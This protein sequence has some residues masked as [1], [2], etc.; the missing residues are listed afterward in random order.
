LLS[1][2]SETAI[3][4]SKNNRIMTNTHALLAALIACSTFASCQYTVEE[5]SEGEDLQS[6]TLTV[7]LDPSIWTATTR[8]GASAKATTTPTLPV[9]YYLY[10]QNAEAFIADRQ[11]TSGTDLSASFAVSK[12]AYTLYAVT[13][14]EM[15]DYTTVQHSQNFTFDPLALQTDVCLGHTDVTISQYYSEAKSI[16]IHACHVFARL[17]LTLSGVPASFTSLT[18]SVPGL[19]TAISWDGVYADTTTAVLPLALAEATSEAEATQ[20]WAVAQYLYPN[21]QDSL[22]LALSL[23]GENR[24][25]ES[26]RATISDNL[27]AG[28]TLQINSKYAASSA[29]SNIVVDAWTTTEAAEPS[30]SAAGGS[31]SQEPG[32]QT[33]YQVGDMYAA[34]V[35]VVE[36]DTE[37]RTLLLMGTQRTG[38]VSNFSTYL[39]EA[40]LATSWSIPT[41]AQ[42]EVIVGYLGSSVTAFNQNMQAK[43]SQASEVG[44]DDYFALAD[45]DTPY[46]TFYKNKYASAVAESSA[47]YVFPVAVISTAVQ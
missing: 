32:G 42:W 5:A 3:F 31:V 20:T 28:N 2:S 33:S 4:A 24:D 29:S 26:L 40:H 43:D 15:G 17:E 18:A 37:A 16:S 10:D 30:W 35:L 45:V 41:K 19:Y 25:A 34:H 23:A 21:S 13:G 27:V 46:Y 39:P 6:Q 38:Q 1:S 14:V 47:V 22:R 7:S 12:G 44:V 8:A 11:I 9:H 36:A